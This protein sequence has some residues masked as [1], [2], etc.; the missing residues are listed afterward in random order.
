MDKRSSL[1]YN[2]TGVSYLLFSLVLSIIFFKERCFNFDSA[3]VLWKMIITGDFSIE[4][5][6]NGD[7]ICQSIPLL[8][9]KFKDS[10][11]HIAIAYSMSIVIMQII[12]YLIITL[13]LKD[14]ESGIIY[15]LTLLIFIRSSFYFPCTEV[16]QGMP[17]LILQ[18][19]VLKKYI[20]SDS[21]KKILYLFSSAVLSIIL[22]NFHVLLLLP[23][24]FIHGYLLIDDNFNHK[25]ELSISAFLLLLVTFCKRV[26][27]TV[28]DYE[29]QKQIPIK[30][31]VELLPNTLNLPSTKYFYYFI[32]EYWIFIAPVFIALIIFQLK[33]RKIVLT[34]YYWMGFLG[35]M[36]L[37]FQTHYLGESPMMYENYYIVISFIMSLGLVFTWK[38]F[39]QKKCV[40]FIFIFFVVCTSFSI[41][42]ARKNYSLRIDYLE[43]LIA[44]G[45]SQPE[46]KYILAE[47]NYPESYAWSSWALPFET[48]VLSSM[49]GAQNTITVFSTANI[50]EAIKNAALPNAFLCP[51]WTF[52]RFKIPAINN[53][54]FSLPNTNYKLI[55]EKFITGYNVEDSKKN[56]SIFATFL[57]NCNFN[58]ALIIDATIKNS[59]KNKIYS[60]NSK[61]STYKLSV[62]LSSNGGLANQQFSFLIEHDFIDSL[63]QRIII[64]LSKADFKRYTDGGFAKVYLKLNDVVVSESNLIEM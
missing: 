55:N 40:I 19:S 33:S 31:R 29:I 5:F 20:G 17:F 24:L 14:S 63:H 32:T 41:V 43:R 8:L 22:L 25:R 39:F 2:I 28:S 7:V 3:F 36:L 56:I 30:K 52:S 15:I 48:A 58:G 61:D 47:E 10:L 26:I 60:G 16:Q 9:I 57:R 6:R 62:Y 13:I 50:P 11:Q 53:Y 34:A 49:S 44:F 54:I 4:H 64:D 42:C 59:G 38:E 12:V 51:M 27:C 1:I 35:I 21:S 18:L 45:Q 23:A 46:K 37:I